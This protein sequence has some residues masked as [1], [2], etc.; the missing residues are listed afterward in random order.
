[1]TAEWFR[2]HVE[3]AIASLQKRYFPEA[4]VVLDEIESVFHALATTPDYLRELKGLITKAT[5]CLDGIDANCRHFSSDDI[6]TLVN[7][8]RTLTLLLYKVVHAGSVCLTQPTILPSVEELGQVLTNVDAATIAVERAIKARLGDATDPHQSGSRDE[9]C[10]SILTEVHGLQAVCFHAK[11]FFFSTRTRAARQCLL[12]VDG[13]AGSGKSHCFAH[14]ARTRTE[15]GL[16]TLLIL[17]QQLDASIPAG[18]QILKELSLQGSLDEC[19]AELTAVAES[20]G[21]KALILV[22]AINES[23]NRAKWQSALPKLLAAVQRYPWIALAVSVRSCFRTLV[24]GNEF[25][26]DSYP[27]IRHTG[28]AGHETEAASAYFKAFDLSPNVPLLDPAFTNGLFLRL[29]CEVARATIGSRA[30]RHIG[31]RTLFLAFLRRVEEQLV[32]GPLDVDPSD[33]VVTRAVEDIAARMAANQTSWLPRSEARDVLN[34]I[35][36]STDWKSSLLYHLLAEDVLAEDV[37]YRAG[38]WIESVRFSFER[39]SDLAVAEHLLRNATNEAE[40]IELMRSKAVAGHGSRLGG[41]SLLVEGLALVLPEVIG[42][43]I[44][45]VIPSGTECDVAED[46]FV[47]SLLWREPA[48]L[49]HRALQLVDELFASSQRPSSFVDTMVMLSAVPDH[50][51]NGD[52]LDQWL[53]GLSMPE[54]DCE[55]ATYLHWAWDGTS[56]MERLI[57]WA[58]RTQGAP[59]DPAV[60]NLAGTT[61]AW[62]LSTPNRFLRDTAT[63]SLVALFDGRLREW[64]R[65][66]E[67]F[68]RVDDPYI[69]E[70]VCAAGCGVVLRT[71]ALND[72]DPV[73]RTLFNSYFLNQKCLPTHVLTRDYLRLI[74]E[75]GAS[76][77]GSPK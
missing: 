66:E 43:E 55:W 44:L 10:K 60:R 48:A 24:F 49:G 8:G 67:H 4:H 64:A 14:V 50:P 2:H 74:I 61:L 31:L 42:V 76:W 63:K 39:F 54:R 16:P 40:V 5:R 12:I 73:A 75:W 70:R 25:D 19:L 71:S 9:N 28:F 18:V 59:L 6:F 23:N 62:A 22:D 3:D 35:L 17:G 21:A 27:I 65:L 68:R 51:L 29:Y 7:V 47:R 38:E 20:K 57:S 69:L 11:E 77:A 30:S 1:M 15:R 52:R 53:G 33:H 45:D 46:A 37:A 34:G 56:A 41:A 72:V 58:S 13:E 36:P 26:F 32:S